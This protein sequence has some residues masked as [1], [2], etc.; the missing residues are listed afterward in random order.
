MFD[1]KSKSILLKEVDNLK[2]LGI[3]LSAK[4]TFCFDFILTV[5]SILFIKSYV[6]IFKGY[7]VFFV[8]EDL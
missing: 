3:I 5:V 1:D 4:K 8:N 2:A 6:K 7:Y